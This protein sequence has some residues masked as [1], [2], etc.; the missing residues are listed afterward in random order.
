VPRRARRA[1]KLIA[2][3]AASAKAAGLRYV[4]EGGPGIT[5]RRVGKGF[6]YFNPDHTPVHDDET[7]S[8]IR[9]LAIPPAWTEV[10]IA[11][12]AH[13]HLQATGRDVK[14]RKQYRYHARWREV[15]DATKYDRMIV[16]GRLLPAIRRR[17]GRDLA[18]PGLP[19]PKILATV[20]RLLESTL[21]RVGNEEYAKSNQS[22]GLTTMR[23]RHVDVRGPRIRFQFKGKSGKLHEV[24]LTDR[25][26]ARI[27]KRT[28]D[29]PG[30][31][32]FQYVDEAGRPRTIESTDVNAYLRE[33]TGEE[34]TAKDFRTWA[35]T[36]LAAR[37]LQEARAVESQRQAKRELTRAIETVAKRLGNT[38]TICRKCY[39][40]PAVINGYLDGSLIKGLQRKVDAEIKSRR[41]A[42][43]AEEEAVLQFL[44]RDLG[45]A[46]SAKQQ[47][48]AASGKTLTTLLRRSL[49]DVKGKAGSGKR[50][51]LR[52]AKVA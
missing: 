15:R 11:P 47:P 22:F 40:H 33:I 27:V 35:G 36:V 10:W 18:R 31:E 14:G 6:V 46:K 28:Q 17:T 24:A 21:I 50:K 25:R 48:P 29:L 23:D 16:F 51:D 19:R 37:A 30:Y 49:K 4:T 12:A 26:L 43:P 8:R 20:V 34:F 13:A 42:L 3:P 45:R 38:A 9:A 39:I 41:G 32:L 44:R 5:R 7:L 2:D 52:K 1:L